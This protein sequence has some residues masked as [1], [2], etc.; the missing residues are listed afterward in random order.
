MEKNIK[1]KS[2]FVRLGGFTHLL[3]VLAHLNLDQ[4]E[5]TLELVCIRTLLES[6]YR[7]M[8]S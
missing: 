7:L 5:C 8:I 1:W 4:I 3:H 2:E 6:I